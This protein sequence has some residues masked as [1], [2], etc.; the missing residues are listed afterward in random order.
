VQLRV[1]AVHAIAALRVPGV[2]AALAGL[3]EDK[4]RAV[5]DALAQGTRIHGRRTTRSMAVVKE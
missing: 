4:E 5:R 3:A 1:A 2:S